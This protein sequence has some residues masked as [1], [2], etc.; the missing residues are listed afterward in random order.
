MVSH[1]TKEDLERE[2]HSIFTQAIEQD[3]KINR[4]AARIDFNY[5]L[6]DGQECDTDMEVEKG[7][8]LPAAGTKVKMI[9]APAVSKRGQSTGEGFDTVRTLLP[10]QVTCTYPHN[11]P[12][13]SS[14]VSSH[15]R[16]G[17]HDRRRGSQFQD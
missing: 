6:P 16:H 1:Q 12:R 15:H 17:R 5:K 3:R 13:R 7:E 10:M 2:L 14:A 4:Q 11:P 9:L 8:V